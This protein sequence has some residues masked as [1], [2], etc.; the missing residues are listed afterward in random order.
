MGANGV[1]TRVRRDGLLAFFH[2][3][4]AVTVLLALL[5]LTAQVLA[6]AYL[7]DLLRKRI[8]G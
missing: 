2:T 7:K 1:A 4:S 8:A 6:L 5:S 3:V